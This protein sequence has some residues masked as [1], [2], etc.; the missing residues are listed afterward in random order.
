MALSRSLTRALRHRPRAHLFARL[1]A[2]VRLRK[3]RLRLAA[4]DDHMLR[5]IGLTRDEAQHEAERPAW[6]VPRHWRA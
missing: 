1:A 3:E 6:D 5:D 2:M 4:L